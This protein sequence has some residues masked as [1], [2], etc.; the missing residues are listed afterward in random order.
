MVIPETEISPMEKILKNPGLVHLAENIF[1]NLSDEA[2]KICRLI[3]KV[4]QMC[5]MAYLQ[6]IWQQIWDLLNLSKSCLHI[7]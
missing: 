4:A 1:N 2:V 6:Y 7:L 5:T 3:L